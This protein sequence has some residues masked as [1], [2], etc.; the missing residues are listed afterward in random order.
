MPLNIE[1][2]HQSLLAQIKRFE[3]HPLDF[4]FTSNNHPY[5]DIDSIHACFEKEWVTVTPLLRA[6][7]LMQDLADTIFPKKPYDLKIIQKLHNIFLSPPLPQPFIFLDTCVAKI[8]TEISGKYRKQ[9]SPQLLLELLNFYKL[10]TPEFL[11]IIKPIL[12]VI[13]DREKSFNLVIKSHACEVLI[14]NYESEALFIFISCTLNIK[15]EEKQVLFQSLTA[16][17]KI[18]RKFLELH[19]GIPEKDL[20]SLKWF[21]FSYDQLR[22][23]GEWRDSFSNVVR[24]F[25]EYLKKRD[26]REAIQIG[27]FLVLRFNNEDILRLIN[28]EISRD[29]DLSHGKPL[30]RFIYRQIYRIMQEFRK[31]YF[32]RISSLTG[33]FRGSPFDLDSTNRYDW[34]EE[35]E[36]CLFRPGYTQ[37]SI[38]QPILERWEETQNIQRDFLKGLI[39]EKQWN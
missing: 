14:N 15:E 26:K 13:L 16:F 2:I 35:P 32:S 17:Q 38:P 3:R 22:R 10:R 1:D 4:L 19:V 25:I 39:Q 30:T 11:I 37:I 31:N 36:N 7:G 24:R 20:I 6:K 21:G 18:Y 34:D 12:Q 28:Y 27:R 33:G 9:V 23:K 29:P 8:L 5:L